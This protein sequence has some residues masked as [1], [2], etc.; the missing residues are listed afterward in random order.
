MNRNSILFGLVIFYTVFL[1]LMG[2]W[3]PEGISTEE[4]EEA[5]DSGFISWLSGSSSTFISGVGDFLNSIFTS[6]SGFPTI[7]N[8]IVFSPLGI[9]GIWLLVDL[10]IY[11]TPFIGGG[12]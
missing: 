3:N 6:I 9:M 10:L 1:G 8:V 7:V 11:I 4:S 2:I 12:S 5:D